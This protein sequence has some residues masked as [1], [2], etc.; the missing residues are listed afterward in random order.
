MGETIERVG[1]VTEGYDETGAATGFFDAH[2]ESEDGKRWG[3]GPE[4]VPVAEAIQWARGHA[5]R[6][7]VLLADDDEALYSAGDQQFED[8]LPEWSDDLAPRR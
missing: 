1:F 5:R 3:Q 2:W 6:V 8:P 4:R 7:S